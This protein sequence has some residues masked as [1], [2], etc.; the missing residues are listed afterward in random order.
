MTRPNPIPEL[1]ESVPT[2]GGNGELED[3]NDRFR[4][5]WRYVCRVSNGRDEWEWVPL[6][7]EDVLHP[8][9]GDYVLKSHIHQ[10]ICHYLLTV[11]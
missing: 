5:G 7:E 6:T 10:S 1:A 3:W 8:Q 11:L 4:Y 2:V 9:M